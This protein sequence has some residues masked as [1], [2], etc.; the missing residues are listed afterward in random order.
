MDTKNARFGLNWC[1]ETH[2]QSPITAGGQLCRPSLA[3]PHQLPMTS[4]RTRT[5]SRWMVALG[6]S[7]FCVAALMLVIGLLKGVYTLALSPGHSAF[8]KLASEVA[9]LIQTLY[10][11]VAIHAPGLTAS[12][13]QS[14][15]DLD[16]R[17]PI[18]ASEHRVLWLHYALLFVGSGLFGRGRAQLRH[19]AEYENWAVRVQH[20]EQLRLQVR[21][22]TV[23]LGV[24]TVEVGAAPACKLSW[25]TTWWGVLALTVGAGLATEVFKVLLGLAKLP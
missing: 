19:I 12:L 24:P 17:K 2:R 4:L 20:E 3:T 22:G 21:R 14:A 10:A 8:A 7:L 11:A 23:A 1:G 6:A 9:R 13:W 18:W 15:A 5:A 25:H 16:L